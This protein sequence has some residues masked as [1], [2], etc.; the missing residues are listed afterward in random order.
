MG[1]KS[2][3]YEWNAGRSQTSPKATTAVPV[4]GANP[5]SA[6]GKPFSIFVGGYGN[7]LLEL[8]YTT[9]TQFI[10]IDEYGCTPT[11]P[12]GVIQ[13]SD[14]TPYRGITVAGSARMVNKDKEDKGYTFLS[15]PRMF[16]QIRINTTSYFKDPD[17]VVRDG[18]P[19]TAI[20][21]PKSLWYC[22]LFEEEEIERINILP[23][24]TWD[25]RL[26]YYND[27]GFQ[28]GGP[29]GNSFAKVSDGVRCFVKYTLYDGSDALIATKLLQN[30]IAVTPD[31]LN[32][33]RARMI[34]LNYGK[35]VDNKYVLPPDM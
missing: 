8:P 2:Q 33:F 25:I 3:V 30:G 18:L 31:N 24:Q 7:N 34:G 28:N 12:R 27:E 4:G 22:S 14:T 6:A 35:M 17:G 26:T 13:S 15:G 11:L 5:D 32:W 19:G 9:S 29:L 21:Y 23:N 10:V 1:I 20:P 16:L